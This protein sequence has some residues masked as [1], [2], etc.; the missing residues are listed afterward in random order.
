MGCHYLVVPG[1]IIFDHLA[2]KDKTYATVE[3]A[4]HG[5]Q[6]CQPQ[7]G[8]TVKRTFDFVDNWLSRPGRF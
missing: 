4:T 6:P 2:A 3:G 8:D 7:Y 5:F 1:E